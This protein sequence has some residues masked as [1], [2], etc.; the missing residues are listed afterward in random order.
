MPEEWQGLN[1]DN[2]LFAVKSP[3]SDSSHYEGQDTEK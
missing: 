2:P 3:D 1:R